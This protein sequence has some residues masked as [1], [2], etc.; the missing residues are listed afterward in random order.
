MDSGLR[1]GAGPRTRAWTRRPGYSGPIQER[2]RPADPDPRWRCPS[3]GGLWA[4]LS[5]IPS[6]RAVWLLRPR[7]V[8]T[9]NGSRRSAIRREGGLGPPPRR[10]RTR[11][12][13]HGW[14]DFRRRRRRPAIQNAAEI[15]DTV[16]RSRSEAPAEV[17][18]PCCYRQR[19]AG[20]LTSLVCGLCVCARLEM[21]ETV[22]DPGLPACEP[23]PT[24]SRHPGRNCPSALHA[25][26]SRK[27][28]NCNGLL[29]TTGFVF[30]IFHFAHSHLPGARVFCLQGFPAHRGDCA[31]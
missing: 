18:K 1:S 11:L 12:V 17:K 15:A 28:V 24:L 20:S 5:Q 21:V 29:S 27:V 4:C 26:K 23:R 10:P 7:R 19:G 6:R 30:H 9:H 22:T 16:G 13:Q 3:R 31:L 14:Q 8:V 25:R 2:W